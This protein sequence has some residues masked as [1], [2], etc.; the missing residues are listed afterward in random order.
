MRQ[1]ETF[2]I[3]NH[4]TDDVCQ[5][6]HITQDR[7]TISG[8]AEAEINVDGYLKT[9][10]EFGKAQKLITLILSLMTVPCVY[11]NSIIIFIGDEPPWTCAS[12]NSSTL[13]CDKNGTFS[14]S[15]SFYL[16]R[17]SMSRSS[18]NF[19]KPQTYSVVT[20]VNV[21]ILLCFLL[22]HLFFSIFFKRLFL[23][24]LSMREQPT[25]VSG[26]LNLLSWMVCWR[27][28]IWMDI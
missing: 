10:G 3:A 27:Y 2:V 8:T 17:C 12:D 11:Q 1:N 18:W 22:R 19:T 26:Q 28:Y 14:E 13:P 16:K 5:A 4:V 21:S 9:I 15:H 24:E 23:V 7:S 25:I 6:T 20:Q